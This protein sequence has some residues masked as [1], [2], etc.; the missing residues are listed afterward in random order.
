VRVTVGAELTGDEDVFIW[1][2]YKLHCLLGKLV[3][4]R[5]DFQNVSNFEKRTRARYSSVALPVISS[6]ALL[7][8]AMRMFRST[9][10]G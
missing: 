9:G 8:R 3:H 1:G 4:V 7:Y 2:S 6:Y 10:I 5:K